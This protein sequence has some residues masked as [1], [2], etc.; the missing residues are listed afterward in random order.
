M[1]QIEIRSGVF[2]ITLQWQKGHIGVVN[3]NVSP[4]HQNDSFLCCINQKVATTRRTLGFIHQFD[5]T[6]DLSLEI[7]YHAVFSQI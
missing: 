4:S 6:P 3:L 7:N 2:K 5:P 1:T